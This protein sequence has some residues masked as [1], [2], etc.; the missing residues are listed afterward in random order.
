MEVTDSLHIIKTSYHGIYTATY[1]IL[2]EGLTLIDSG[3]RESW[4]QD[5][6][7]YI[8]SQGRDPGEVRLVVL[9][10]NHDD[11]A[12]SARQIREETGAQ[13]AAGVETARFLD[14][15]DSVMRWEELSFAGWLS[16]REKANI[17]EGTDY[18]GAPRR[19]RRPLSVDR[20]LR[21]GDLIQAGPLIFHVL[22]APGHTI[23]SIALHEPQAK[24]LFTGDTVSGTGTALD[25]LNVIQSIAAFRKTLARFDALDIGTLLMA[26]PYLP[27]ADAVLRDERAK[28]MIRV[29]LGAPDRILT[30]IKRA[31]SQ[32]DGAMTTAEVSAE[33]CA[34]LGPNRP[35]QHSHGTV[36]LSLL[37]LLRAGDVTAERARGDIRWTLAG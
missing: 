11:H 30:E 16:D 14:E 37:E 18:G 8:R 29:T 35:D 17:R 27:Y 3:E 2:G 19:S 34:A 10:H 32:G 9:T 25:D 1:L 22:A 6:K 7:P 23:D 26:H 5:I 13:L 4:E 12:G 28:D 31:L 20:L 36:R 33:V 24:L 21:D 15:P